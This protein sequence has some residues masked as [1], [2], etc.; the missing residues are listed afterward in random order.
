MQETSRF[1]L[2]LAEGTDHF[3]S[4]DFN[5]NT[6]VIFEILSHNGG[7]EMQVIGKE[8]KSLN[9]DLYLN[10][11]G[12]TNQD[13][14]VIIFTVAYGTKIRNSHD[15]EAP[16]TINI[17]DYGDYEV[18]SNNTRLTS[19][20]EMQLQ[21]GHVYI[22]YLNEI[23]GAYGT[24]Y[25]WQIFEINGSDEIDPN[26]PNHLNIDLVT[27]ADGSDEELY[28]MIEAADNETIDLTEYWSVGDER[29]IHLSSIGRTTGYDAGQEAQDI[30]FVLMDTNHYDLA[31]PIDNKT[32]CSFV[33]GQKDCLSSMNRMYYYS[34]SPSVST[35]PRA[36]WSECTGRTWLNTYYLPAL[37]SSFSSLFKPFNLYYTIGEATGDT[38]SPV[39]AQ[40]TD[41]IALFAA[42]EILT[43]SA[44]IDSN[45]WASYSQIEYYKTESNRI[46]KLGVEEEST[47]WWTRSGAY[48]SNG[49]CFFCYIKKDGTL[50]TYPGYQTLG[51]APFGVI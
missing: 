4:G 9:Y 43:S 34:S 51:F 33:V 26:D 21:E 50:T 22:M 13:R 2:K 14:E 20:T 36:N 30:T 32:K 44:W 7:L 35:A 15:S 41:T 31:T 5:Y 11:P 1:K 29:I 8:N 16:L 3:S 10:I 6:R 48:A 18:Y 38:V 37:P 27:W 45:A 23:A 28:A 25:R 42:E 49:N 47:A 12:F 40:C 39:T 17:N 46:K 24:V 19:E